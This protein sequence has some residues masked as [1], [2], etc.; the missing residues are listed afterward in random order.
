MMSA[1]DDRSNSTADVF[2]KE[3]GQAAKTVQIFSQSLHC[4]LWGR[5]GLGIFSC[6][7]IL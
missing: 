6:G 2:S 5:A 7:L 1:E 3:G 4:L